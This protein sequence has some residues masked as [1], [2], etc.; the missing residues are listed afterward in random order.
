MLGELDPGAPA[1]HGVR[2][3]DPSSRSEAGAATT[4]CA[5]EGDA[6]VLLRPWRRAARRVRVVVWYSRAEP[7]AVLDVGGTRFAL[8]TPEG[9]APSSAGSRGPDVPLAR[10]GQVDVVAVAVVPHV[11][12]LHRRRR[13]LGCRLAGSGWVRP[14]AGRVRTISLEQAREHA[15]RYAEE[16]FVEAQPRPVT[17]LE[18]NMRTAK[19]PPKG[20]HESCV[21]TSI[22]VCS[23]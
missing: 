6:A 20:D 23:R 7:G 10:E 3:V 21:H 4:A 18:P 15:G 9:Q 8:T 2:L 5:P 17:C 12:R 1:R 11:Q 16:V 13:S 22:C 19:L 14:A